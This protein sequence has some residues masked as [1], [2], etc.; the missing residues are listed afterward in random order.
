MNFIKVLKNQSESFDKLRTDGMSVNMIQQ[1]P[2]MLSL[3]KHVPFFFN[4]LS[5]LELLE[6]RKCTD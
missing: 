1:N 6:A 2:F 3:S 4:K 5:N